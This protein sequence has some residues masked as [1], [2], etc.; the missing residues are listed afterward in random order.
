MRDEVGNYRDAVFA[1]DTFDAD[2]VREAF[3][4]DL[5]VWNLAT[6]FFGPEDARVR[7]VSL[8]LPLGS[9]ISYTYSSRGSWDAREMNGRCGEAPA[10]ALTVEPD[11][12]VRDTVARWASDC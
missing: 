7:Q 8:P 1:T 11:L 6:V 9:D 3:E 4:A 2:R 5:P 10:R 12:V